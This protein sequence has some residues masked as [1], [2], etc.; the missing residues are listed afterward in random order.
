MDA[1]AESERP[2]LDWEGAVERLG[3]RERI[4]QNVAR[5]FLEGLP[6]IRR[7]ISEGLRGGDARQVAVAAHGLKG[8]AA[9]IGA[10]PVADGAREVERLADDG[11][12]PAAEEAWSVLEPHLDTLVAAVRVRLQG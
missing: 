11:D 7:T 4:L 12:L 6:D 2:T 8:S 9:S 5:V 1:V 10:D 3:G